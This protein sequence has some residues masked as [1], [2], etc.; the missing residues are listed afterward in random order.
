MALCLAGRRVTVQRVLPDYAGQVK[1]S[2]LGKKSSDVHKLCCPECYPVAGL[3]IAVKI[4][5]VYNIKLI[6]FSV[7]LLEMHVLFIA[8][9]GY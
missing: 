5:P 4:I 9:S 3:R 6:M 1:V 2:S 8:C 7:L